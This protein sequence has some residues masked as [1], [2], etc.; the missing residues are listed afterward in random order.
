[1]DLLIDESHCSI[2]IDEMWQGINVHTMTDLSLLIQWYNKVEKTIAASMLPATHPRGKWLQ[3]FSSALW[4][5]INQL[6]PKLLL[7]FDDIKET[8]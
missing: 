6:H 3:Q 5:R 8:A 1:M 2:G 4:I 7:K